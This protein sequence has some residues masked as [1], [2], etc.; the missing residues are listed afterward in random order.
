MYDFTIIGGGIVGLSVGM[1]LSRRYPKA[2]I[3]LVE[4]ESTLSAHQ[5]G[6]NSG[7]IHSGIYYKP[8]S[9]K[10]ELARK[11]N[12]EMTLFCKQHGIEHDICGKV[13]VA[14]N[15]SELP[16]LD[17]LYNRGLENQLE[18]ERIS[19]DELKAIE[20]HVDGIRAIRVPS[21]GIVNYEQ[22]AE[23]FADLIKKNCGEIALNTEVKDIVAKDDGV[24]VSTNH[25]DY[26]SR[27]L[28]NCSGLLS[29]RVAKM[30]NIKTD[31][32]IVPFRGEYYELKPEKRHLVNNLIYP[33]PN[34]D[35]PF[36]GVHF[37][38]MMDGRI[39]I[40]PNAVL[41]FKREGYKKS[42]INLKDLFET[43]TYPGFLKLVSQNLSEGLKEMVRSYCK[44][45]FIKDVQR[46]IPDITEED[47]QPSK[48]GVRAQA[49]GPKGNLLDD[50]VIIQH[51]R[52]I[53]VCNAPSPAATASIEIGKKVVSYFEEHTSYHVGN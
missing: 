1:E 46:F 13:I 38:R 10:A 31:M 32:K 51:D 21:T 29:D 33:V 35:F 7:V 27:F 18:V 30:A 41:S 12:E 4:K 48:A 28:I 34:P 50:F 22:V 25:G 47:I 53:H 6:R 42:D 5:T 16:L 40:G 37:T 39:M 20:P 45:A 49:L 15:E 3:V 19:V 23:V 44:K 52:S 14:T 2:S 36:L 43:L 17:N 9:L 11:G 26:Q 8:G 24:K